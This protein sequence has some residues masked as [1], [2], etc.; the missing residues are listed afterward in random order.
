MRELHRHKKRGSTYELLG[1]AEAQVSKTTDNVFQADAFRPL[2][3]GDRLA[4]YRT[5]DGIRLWVRFEDEFRDGR[6]ENV[7]PARKWWPGDYADEM[8]P[9]GSFT[10]DRWILGKSP[11]GWVLAPEDRDQA[12]DLGCRLATEGEVVN[13][14]WVEPRG[15]AT[16]TIFADGTWR[17][18]VPDDFTHCWEDGEIEQSGDSVDEVVR[19][20][21][22][23]DPLGPGDEVDVD[24]SFCKWGDADFRL[25]VEDG[26]AKFV[27]VEAEV[28]GDHG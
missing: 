4:V 10:P 1:I 7:T 6:F 24:L 28:G 19:Y 15:M 11:A 12:A 5:E 22:D 9:G 18:S 23:A 17:G 3:E 27:A 21:L 25:V 2:R 26:R 20:I 8:M 13:F 14:I 16:I